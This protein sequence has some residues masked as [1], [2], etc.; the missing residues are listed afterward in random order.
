L[1]ITF[2]G[3]SVSRLVVIRRRSRG[4]D[5]GERRFDLPAY[6]LIKPSA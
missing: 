1:V 6:K 5:L 4:F 2:P 3:A